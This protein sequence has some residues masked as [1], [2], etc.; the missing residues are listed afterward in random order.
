MTLGD[1]MESCL[2]NSL[3]SLNAYSTEEQQRERGANVVLY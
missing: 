3:K 2:V 1:P